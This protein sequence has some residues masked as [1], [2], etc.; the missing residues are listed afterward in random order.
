MVKQ[1]NQIMS[2]PQTLDLD[3]EVVKRRIVKKFYK[4]GCRGGKTQSQNANRNTQNASQVSITSKWDKEK[5][6]LGGKCYKTFLRLKKARA[7]DTKWHFHP[8]LT[9]WSVALKHFSVKHSSLFRYV[10][11]YD[12]KSFMKLVPDQKSSHP[13]FFENADGKMTFISLTFSLV[14]CA[15]IPIA[16]SKNTRSPTYRKLGFSDLYSFPRT[17]LFISA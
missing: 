12:P 2:L 7:F 13:V 6:P 5:R 3:V 17:Y 14:N 8:G 10:V 1:L 9:F 11:S 16:P 15:V 4:I